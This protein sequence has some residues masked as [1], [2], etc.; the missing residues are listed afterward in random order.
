MAA[1]IG[2]WLLSRCWVERRPNPKLTGQAA[3]ADASAGIVVFADDR[4]RKGRPI[5]YPVAIIIHAVAQLLGRRGGT[6]ADEGTEEIRAR[7]GVAGEGARCADPQGRATGVSD[8][9]CR[10]VDRAVAIIVRTIADLALL[11]GTDDLWPVVSIADP[12]AEAIRR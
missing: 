8:L 4:G 2:R 9:A 12:V 1:A 6:L 5:D 7:V 10:V 3:T 11:A